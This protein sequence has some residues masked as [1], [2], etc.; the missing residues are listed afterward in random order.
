MVKKA[1]WLVKPQTIANCFRKAGFVA[2]NADLIDDETNAENVL[3]LNADEVG[4]A[5]EEFNKLVDCDQGLDCYGEM[6][7]QEIVAGIQGD[8][9]DEVDDDDAD[10]S[11]PVAAE[12]AMPTNNEIMAALDVLRSAYEIRGD[13]M[14]R[15]YALEEEVYDMTRAAKKQSKITDFFS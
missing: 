15:F 4:V 13:N 2:Q 12:P 11:I 3:D 14:E 6:T 5:P 10:L 7:D 8:S 9:Q 1:W